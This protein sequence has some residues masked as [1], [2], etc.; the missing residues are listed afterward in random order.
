MSW[1][2]EGVITHLESWCQA[3]LGRHDSPGFHTYHEHFRSLINAKI[4][5]RQEEHHNEGAYG[6]SKAGGCVRAACLARAGAPR[7]PISGSDAVTFE[8]G[9]IVEVM[10]LAV[11]QASGFTVTG[12]QDRVRLAGLFSSATDGVLTAGPVDLPYPLPV[13]IKS[14]GYKMGKPGQRRGF[15]ALPAAGV[16]AEQP[17][18]WVQSQ[19]EMAALSSSHSLVLVVAR[20]VIK[21]YEGDRFMPSLAWYAE[22]LR[23]E[24]SLQR[25][26]IAMYDDAANFRDPQDSPPAYFIGNGWANLPAPGDNASGWGG[27][28]QK[29]TGKFNPCNGCDFA[30]LCAEAELSRQLSA[31]LEGGRRP[32]PSPPSAASWEDMP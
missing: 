7:K 1:G 31:S 32:A 19:L 15:A 28:N 24:A 3:N 23:S 22:L 8:L 18:W 26:V 6:M 27:P 14:T 2:H 12:L 30:E 17:G 10:A 21:A 4:L 20:D 11:L 13:S 9:H 29:A 16:R 25:R 5:E